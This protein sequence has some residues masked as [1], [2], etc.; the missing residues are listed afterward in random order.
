MLTD[1]LDCPKPGCR[2]FEV[3]LYN[4][5]VRELLKQNKHHTRYSDRWA[6]INRQVVQA[7][8]EGEARQLAARRY[9][10]EEGFVISGVSNI[11]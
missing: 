1:P 8:D 10:P 3:Q 5:E 2:S 6:D 11:H 9:P 4:Q 7:H